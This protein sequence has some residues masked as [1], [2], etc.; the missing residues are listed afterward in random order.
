ML[1]LILA[2][3]TAFF[4]SLGDVLGKKMLKKIDVYIVAWVWSAFSLPFLYGLMLIEKIPPLGPSFFGAACFSLIFGTATLSYAKNPGVK[5]KRGVINIITSPLEIPKQIKRYLKKGAEKNDFF[6]LWFLAGVAEG[7]ANTVARLGSGAWD[8]F[9]LN[10]D[11]PAGYSALM[12]PDYV[13]DPDPEA[14][15]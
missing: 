10:I 15:P 4:T 12:Q 11:L 5:F 6:P 9:T 2:F 8:V 1:W 3:L 7:V 14:S 13:F